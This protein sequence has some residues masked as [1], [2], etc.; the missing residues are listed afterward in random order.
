M[1]ELLCFRP[2]KGRGEILSPSLLYIFDMGGVVTGNTNVIPSVAEYLEITEEKFF[3]LAGEDWKKL[4]I[5]KVDSKQFWMRIS[6]KIH[7]EIKEDLF[8]KFFHPKRNSEVIQIIR[9]LKKKYR[10]VCGTNTF[11]IHYQYHVKKGD[12]HF[13]EMVY[14]S[15][16]L[17]IAKPDL[18][19][20]QH[21]LDKEKMTEEKTIFIDDTKE[22][23]I[24]AKRI[25]I[26]SI[27]FVDSYSLKNKL[28]KYNYIDNNEL[29]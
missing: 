6:Q 7:R 13:F 5:G 26:Q 25:G 16:L 4:L 27:R 3:Q 10:V 14:A 23:V 8:E 9:D 18:R 15:H 19:F 11:Q 12:Y 21:I 20:Y 28:I 22:N 1:E 2:G 24:A 29:S 17:G